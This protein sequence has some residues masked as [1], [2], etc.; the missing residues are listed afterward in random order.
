[1]GTNVYTERQALSDLIKWSLNRPPWQRDAPK[2]IVLQE[3]DLSTT[4]I[5]ELTEICLDPSPSFDPLT[6]DDV[7]AGM[8]T[9][10]P[11]SIISVKNTIGINALAKLKEKNKATAKRTVTVYRSLTGNRLMMCWM[12]RCSIPAIPSS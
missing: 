7:K 5:E 10:E 1:M 3:N 9:D 2:R 4:D 12:W 11:V 8:V 6:S